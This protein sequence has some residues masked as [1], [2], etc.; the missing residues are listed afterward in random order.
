MRGEEDLGEVCTRTYFE[1]CRLFF[2]LKD[3]TT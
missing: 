3:V 1:I 2:T